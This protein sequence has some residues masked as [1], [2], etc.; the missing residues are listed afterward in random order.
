MQPRRISGL[1]VADGG[2]KSLGMK[3]E[4]AHDAIE[5]AFA[6]AVRRQVTGDDP[7]WSRATAFR[8]KRRPSL[9]RWWRRLVPASW[10]V[11]RAYETI[12]TETALTDLFDLTREPKRPIVWNGSRYFA[13]ASGVKRV[14]LLYLMHLIERLQPRSVLEVG[15]G[16]GGNLFVLAGRYPDIKFSGIELTDGGHAAAQSVRALP[17]LPNKLVEFSPLEVRDLSAHQRV[18][19]HQGSAAQL[20]FPSRSFD[21]VYTIQALEQMRDISSA[22]LRELA[23]VSSGHVAMFEPFMEWNETEQRRATIENKLYFRHSASELPAYG[24][25]VVLAT[26]D[27][28]M[29]CDYGV[30]LV[31]TSAADHTG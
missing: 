19:L 6:P 29:K 30:G 17:V 25:K 2:S 1:I 26:G 9:L 7:E 16:L 13:N 23:R 10:R 3:L 20:P 27:M 5:R 14:H 21:L 8:G 22:A 12:W 11:R 15:S 18:E 4:V 28:P 31:V 24:L